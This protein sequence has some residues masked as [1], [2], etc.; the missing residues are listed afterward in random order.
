MTTAAVHD[1][2]IY[3]ASNRFDLAAA[4]VS[5]VTG[6]SSDFDGAGDEDS[7]STLYAL[8]ATTGQLRWKVWLA[9]P[10]SEVLR[11]PTACS[12]TQSSMLGASP[13]FGRTLRLS[14][15]ER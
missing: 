11:S 8:D 15:D 10:C 1:D 14:G 13:V 7:D 3:V 9:A 6:V 5:G 4:F 2:T 12:T